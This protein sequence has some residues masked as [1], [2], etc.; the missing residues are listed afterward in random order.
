[1]LYAFFIGSGKALSEVV[2]SFSSDATQG[3][4]A[5]YYELLHTQILIHLILQD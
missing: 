2:P 4:G 1:M 5:H 3:I